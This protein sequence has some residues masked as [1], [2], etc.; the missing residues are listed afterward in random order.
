MG[1]AMEP[2][3]KEWAIEAYEELMEESAEEANSTEAV[4]N[5]T[6]A[7][8]E[9]MKKIGKSGNGGPHSGRK[10]KKEVLGE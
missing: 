9:S 1:D 5:S 2:F 8:M 7:V 6:E 4:M 3:I 10:Y